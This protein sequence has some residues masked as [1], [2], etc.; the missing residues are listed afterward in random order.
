MEPRDDGGPAFPI[1]GI[2]AGQKTRWVSM[3]KTGLSIRDWMAGQALMGLLANP[4]C[5]LNQLEMAEAA[6]VYADNMLAERAKVC[7]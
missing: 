6:Y 1:K 5:E 2:V 3:Q 4:N 7:Y